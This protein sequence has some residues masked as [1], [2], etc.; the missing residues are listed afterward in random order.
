MAF[1]NRQ[2]IE[3]FLAQGSALWVFLATCAFFLLLYFSFAGTAWILSRSILPRIG[4]GRAVDMRALRKGQISREIRLSLVSIAMFGLLTVLQ[5]IALRLGWIRLNWE[6]SRATIAVEVVALFLWNEVHFYLCHLLLH[7]RWL[8]RHVHRWH[9]ESVVPTPFATYGFHWIEALMLGSVLLLATLAHDFHPMSLAALPL[10]SL[11]FNTIGHW[12]YDIFSG[13]VRSASVEHG[14]HHRMV[15]GNYGFY[16]PW[17][18]ILFRTQL[19][20]M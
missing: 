17:M 10:L 15:G 4:I 2:W 14:R 13:A 8:Y 1:V 3:D 11:F 5:A 16:L 7:R 20:G 9:H 12:N 18:D 19:K 6:A